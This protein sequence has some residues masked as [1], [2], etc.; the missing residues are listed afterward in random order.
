[1]TVIRVL[2]MNVC[3]CRMEDTPDL[4]MVFSKFDEMMNLIGRYF[5]IIIIIFIIIAIFYFSC[6]FEGE[7]FQEWSEGV[8]AIA[9]TNLDKPLLVREVSDEGLDLIQ[10]NFDP[11]VCVQ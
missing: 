1:M 7:V 5:I 4:E 11:E 10:V 3:V 9:Q 6:S 2:A 8:D